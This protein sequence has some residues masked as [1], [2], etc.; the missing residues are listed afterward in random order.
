MSSSYPE[1]IED[2]S[3]G[4]YSEGYSYATG[5]T[6]WT[7]DEEICEFVVT[8]RTDISPGYGE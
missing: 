3:P 4:R 1:Y 2:P 7:W 5:L 8:T 6:L